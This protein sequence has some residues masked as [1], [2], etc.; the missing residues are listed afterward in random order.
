MPKVFNKYYGNAP[1]NAIYIGRGSP[2]GNPY[3]IGKNG[4][5]EECIAKFEALIRANSHLVTHIKQLR[6]RDLLCYC[7]PRACHGDILLKIANE[8]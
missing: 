1:A 5:R 3:V 4:T 8:D 7:A 2:Y 6:G